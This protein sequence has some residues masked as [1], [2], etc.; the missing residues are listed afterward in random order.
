MADNNPKRERILKIVKER[1]IE[2]ISMWFTDILGFLKSFTITVEEL[3]DALESGVGFDGSSIEGFA[4]IDESDMFAV[5]DMDT[6]QILPWKAYD[7]VEVARMFCDIIT[8]SGEPYAG[9]PRYVLK[10][11]LKR[12]AE[13][14]YT[15]YVGPEL[16][17]FYF[18]DA[19]VPPQVIDKAGYFDQVP[20]DIGRSLRKQT[21]KALKAMEIAV[22][23]SHHEVAH[24]QHEIDLRYHRA[25]R[26][27]DQVMTY[28]FIVK[29]I[30][31][32]NGSY[33]TFMPKPIFGINGSGMHVNMSLFK[34]GENAFS[35]PDREHGLSVVAEHFLA[36]LMK[37]ARELTAL[38][39]QWINSYK[40]LTP[41]Y[42]AP[43]Y[44]SWAKQNR[45]DLIRI[46]AT[47]P[48]KTVNTRLEYR[49]P[50]PACNPYLAFAALL[51]V[52]LEGIEKKYPLEKPFDGNLYEMRYKE[53][54]AAGIKQLP[55]DLYEAIQELEKSE[56]M[57]DV[58]G[59]HVFNN[60]IRNKVI[61]WNEYRTQVTSFELDRYLA[62]L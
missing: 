8:V 42:E 44:I 48:G 13:M 15:F 7:G 12:A 53:R 31:V 56:L 38:T 25:L 17:F 50:D 35:D 43:V 9:D 19:E 45:S 5:P 24:S 55:G 52:G 39:N 3:E 51:H 36:G 1:N 18:K 2:Y 47:K 46:P 21:I 30:A 32:E 23:T 49:A 10:R 28:R 16:E 59:D 26:M 4:R 62:I 11:V 61:E 34:N 27:A 6:F 29:E 40:R 33:A 57:R 37:H 14:G 54:Q 20:S 58:L 22:E 60:F 41:G